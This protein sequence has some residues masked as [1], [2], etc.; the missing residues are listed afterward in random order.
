MPSI[1][2]FPPIAGCVALL[3]FHAHATLAQ[4]GAVQVTSAVQ[5]LHGDPS[6]F[7]GQNAFEPDVGISWLQPGSRFG[8]FQIEI[9]GARRGDAFHTGR[10]YGALR[11]AKFLG[12]R[13]AIEAGDAYFSPAIAGYGFSNLFA[14][15]VTFNGATVGART[16]RSTLTVVAG[17]TTA[18]RNIFGNDPKALGQSLGIVHSTRRFG[19]NLEVNARGSRVR[20]SSLDEFSYT[21]DDSDEASG[22]ARFLLTPSLQ[23]VGDAGLVSY[24][25]TGTTTRERDGSY[26]GGLNWLHSRGYVQLNVS[27]FS[28]GDF[29][30]LNN[31][32]QDREQLFA[33]GEYDLMRRARVSGGW[34]RFRTNLKPEDSLAS[35]RPTP[36]TSGNRGFGAVR[37]QLTSKSTVGFRGE[38]GTRDSHPVGFGLPSESDT[39][40][41]AAE[42]QAA[43]G[44]T[45]AFVRYSGRENVEHLNQSGSYDQRDASAQLFANLRSGSQAFGT[46]MLTRTTSLNGG[47]TYWQAGG[48][49]QLR[50]GARDLWLRAEAN[51]ARNMDLLTRFEVPRESFAFGVNGQVSR[52]TTIQFNVNMD[53][54]V[55][56]STTGSPWLTRSIVRITH[57]LPTGSVFLP[58]NLNGAA[59]EVSR[60]TG[61]IGGLIFADWNANGVQDGDENTLEGIPLRLGAGHTASG[62]DGQF[63]FVNVPAGVRSVGVDTT[64][65]PVDFD[66]PAIAEVQIELSRGDTKRV[67][68]GLLPLGTI[69]GKVIRDANG[70]GKADP[71]EDAIDGAIVVLDGGLRSEQARKGRYQFNAVRSGPHLVKLLLESLPDGAAV[72]GDAEVPATLSR[73]ALAA[74]VTFVV[75]VE[76]RPEIRR[77]F[78]P[79]GGGQGAAAIVRPPAGRGSR[80]AAPATAVRNAPTAAVPSP[81]L[82]NTG[83]ALNAAST[84]GRFTIQIAALNDPGRAKETVEKLKATG[85]PAYLVNPPASDPDAPYRVRVGLYDSR[86]EAQKVAAILEARRG[87]KLWVTREE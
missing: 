61:T 35:T 56:L 15:A 60:G 8:V 39:G 17:K 21:I 66:P 68:F 29:P 81:A 62:R 44:R 54:A 64:A 2:R 42:W 33:V 53:R 9:R 80:P 36:E 55:T 83:A 27:R 10:M 72:T 57:T 12:A 38:Q 67:A 51:A 48:G 73:D 65:L 59:S 45:N 63:A 50:M 69:H 7:A 85:M 52:W 40:M 6:R 58:G 26:I 25:R 11:D 24:R 30:A 86:E 14:P 77:V 22:G 4:Q 84:T 31:P 32:L 49:T 43:I 78:P 76:K 79:R 47:N 37:V 41:W 46:A 75:S 82:T 19:R 28:P 16:D 87:E 1:G 5:T 3:V 70:N 20:T 71:N 34:E 23:L 13:W 74:E 18:W